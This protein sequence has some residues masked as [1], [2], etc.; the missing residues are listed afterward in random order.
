MKLSEILAESANIYKKNFSFIIMYFT[1]FN[2][3]SFFLFYSS[4][5]KEVSQQI[6]A[7]LE[8]LISL[9]LWFFIQAFLIKG[10]NCKYR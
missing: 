5:S 2:I 1:L 3:I 7:L 9:I 6:D 8:L 10:A 4:I